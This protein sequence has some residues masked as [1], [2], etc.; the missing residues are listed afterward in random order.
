[1]TKQKL[2]IKN[3]AVWT[4]IPDRPTSNAVLV[5]DGVIVAIGNEA[6][7][8]GSDASEVIDAAGASVIPAFAEGHAHPIFAG[9]EQQ[10]AK[11]RSHGTV[12]GIADAVA[13][14][15]AENPDIEW[16]LGLGYD[17][18]LVPDGC[19]DA[20]WLDTAVRD[21]PVVL[22]AT[23]YHTVWCN[24][25]AL[26]LAGITSE[27][28]QPENG[29]IVHRP[30]GTPMGTLR[31]WGATDLIFNMLPPISIEQKTEA[32]RWSSRRYIEAGVVFVQD[33]WVEPDDLEAYLQL[34]RGNELELRYNLAFTAQPSEYRSQL[35]LFIDQRSV[36]RSVGSPFLGAETVKIFVDGVIEAGT[37]ALLQPYHDCPGSHGIPNWSI[38]DLTA[39]VTAFDAAG[40]QL[41]L[42]A[43]GDKAIRMALD[44][45]EAVQKENGVRD[46]RPT[47][48]HS[49]LIDP[50]DL[51]RFAELGVIANFE[52]L[53]AQ[54]DSL[55]SILT[56]PRLGE[57][58]GNSQYPIAT[59]LRGGARVSF[60]SDWPVSDHR[61]LPGIA[62]AVTR[63]TKADFPEGGW[64]PSERL[65]LPEALACYCSGTAY[66][67]FLDDSIGQIAVGMS[68]DLIVL[69]RNIF[70]IPSKEIGEVEV[71]TTLVKGRV[72]HS[73]K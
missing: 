6:T 48:A 49:Q 16:I 40:F 65:S 44:A 30:D 1:M 19:F 57:E 73:T 36:V 5:D 29:E 54:Q 37:A 33:A 24:T 53:W 39:A 71:I 8:T 64:M 9:L 38:E 35:Q 23:D 47:I 27:T 56:M 68:A 3:A 42:H 52:P 61:P 66:Q 45:V 4:G 62:V 63:Q 11:V 18:S 28:P 2:L 58:R 25:K 55:Q 32:I 20:K 12:A 14:F 60:G 70:E 17:P 43:I 31:E 13:K 46:R 10:F 41:H 26:E 51:A 22:R 21:R 72:V 59:L 7:D 50:S 69:D 34:A 67:A 15:A